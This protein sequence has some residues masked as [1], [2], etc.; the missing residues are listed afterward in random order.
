MTGAVIPWVGY[1][2]GLIVSII[3]RL[4]K[5]DIISLTVESG[6]QNTGITI[7]MLKFCLGQPAA[8]ITTGDST[9]FFI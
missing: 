9:F 3:T 8:D 2:V 7:F 4:S 1:L 6:I 5:P